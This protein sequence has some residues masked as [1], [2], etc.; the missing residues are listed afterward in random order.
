MKTTLDRRWVRSVFL[1]FALLNGAAYAAPNTPQQN[2]ILK[3]S[4]CHDMDGSGSEPGGIPPLPGYLGAFMDD[5]QGRVYLM[6]VPGVIASGLNNH[7]LAVL[8]NYLN[9]K[10]GDKAN[11]KPYSA[12]EIAQIRAAPLEDVVKYRPEIVKRFNEQGIATG[13]Y[14]WP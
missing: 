10:W 9:D 2:Y 13:S 6:N 11:A 3:C 12:E 4:G 7:D 5:E 1:T 14:P 8:M